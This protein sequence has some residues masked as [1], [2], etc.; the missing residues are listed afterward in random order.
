MSTAFSALD[1]AIS[2]F[3]GFGNT[4]T[5]P[6]ITN[7]NNPGAVQFGP[8]A[9]SYGATGAGPNG[10]AL[11]G[12]LDEGLNALHAVES[13]VFGSGATS[14]DAFVTAYEGGVSVP[15]YSQYIASQLGIGATDAIPA[16]ATQAATVQSAPSPAPAGLPSNVNPATG[17]PYTSNQPGLMAPQGSTPVG[18]GPLSGIINWFNGLPSFGRVAAFVIGAG[19]VIGGIF[20]LRPV[21]SAVSTVTSGAR[22]TAAYFV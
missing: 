11:F 1:T 8:L 12:S 2:Q 22:K 20:F 19:L 4:Q 5:A 13:N 14:P 6:T 17:L 7:G 3:E 9:Q 10:A 21:Q 15:A 18:A 16:G